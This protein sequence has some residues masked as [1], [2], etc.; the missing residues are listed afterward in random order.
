MA[1]A[2]E[3]PRRLGAGISEKAKEI[4]S[5]EFLVDIIAKG[6]EIYAINRGS[7]F[8]RQN[9]YAIDKTLK[10]HVSAGVKAGLGIGLKLVEDMLPEQ[11]RDVGVV[12][13]GLAVNDELETFID[14]KPYVVALSSTE[15][16]FFNFDPSSTLTY[17]IDG[18]TPANVT[19][20]AN[21]HVKV[22]LTT[23]LST[24]K[25]NVSAF[26]KTKALSAVVVI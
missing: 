23:A 10:Q 18:G 9:F 11:V 3:F 12:G 25:H 22:T 24:G 16:E 15:L 6:L 14:K 26:T 5:K 13:V 2:P 1:E 8:I 17:S 19:T 7:D 4:T 21:G 20:D